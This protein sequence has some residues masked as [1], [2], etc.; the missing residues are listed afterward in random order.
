MSSKINLSKVPFRF[1]PDGSVS[2]DCEKPGKI[3]GT[4]LGGIVGC[5]PW[6]TPFSIACRL[7]RLYSE[8][9]DD[10]PSIK[11]GKLLESKI[12]DFIGAT[13][14]EEI[15]EERTG[16][17]EDWPSDFEDEVFGGHIDGIDMETGQ[18]VEVKTTVNPQ[19]WTDGKIPE[20]YW[21]QASLYNYFLKTE[22]IV[23]AVGVLDRD[24]RANPYKWVPEGNVYTFEPGMHPKFEEYKKRAEDWYHTYIENHIT[25]VPDMSNPIDIKI[26]EALKAQAM[27]SK[28]LEEALTEYEGALDMLSEYDEIKASS[29]VVK[30]RIILAMQAQDMEQITSDSHVFKLSESTRST[31]DT[32]AMKRDGIYD[33]YLKQTKTVSFR[34]SRKN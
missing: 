14:A 9:L 32:D 12:L 2:A 18:V 20:H 15:F 29:E 21:L 16:D 3:T 28:E 33:K 17:H 19:D 6:E 5:S 22:G 31:V 24:T 13:A 26:V 23:F 11:A 8:D 4:A 30:A 34:K 7:L 25:P 27:D 10:E 1:N